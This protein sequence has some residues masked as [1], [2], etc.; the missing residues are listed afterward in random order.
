[1]RHKINIPTII[2]PRQ[3]VPDLTIA[4][5]KEK[6]LRFIHEN[7]NLLAD[8]L[9]IFRMPKEALIEYVDHEFLLSLNGYSEEHQKQQIAIEAA[10]AVWS[11]FLKPKLVHAVHAE[12]VEQAITYT[13]TQ[14]TQEVP[15][16]DSKD[17][18]LRLMQLVAE[19]IS[20]NKISNLPV[21]MKINPSYQI[22]PE[23][24]QP[25][26][27]QIFTETVREIYAVLHHLEEPLEEA[28][29]KNYFNDIV[30]TK[31]SFDMLERFQQGECGIEEIKNW[32]L[33]RSDFFMQELLSNCNRNIDCDP[34]IAQ[35][36]K[37]IQKASC[38]QLLKAIFL[39]QETKKD[40]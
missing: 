19:A 2:N 16:E 26:L 5:E 3:R 34:N 11:K 29:Y 13:H 20:E 9:N 36:E 25:F 1:M 30:P 7:K 28:L 23:D 18:R 10:D 22:L 40:A 33:N 24:L 37:L 4:I 8:F 35:N 14:H 38:Y 32:S 27:D 39:T 12:I 15:F 21:Q 17:S 31:F 6:L